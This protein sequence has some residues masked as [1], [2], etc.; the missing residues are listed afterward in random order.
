MLIVYVILNNI[1]NSTQ[2]DIYF[3]FT[4]SDKTRR[5]SKLRLRVPPPD[6][7]GEAASLASRAE[8]GGASRASRRGG[9]GGAARGAREA[10]GGAA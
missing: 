8:G 5:R 1:I 10:A 2:F 4:R 9:G 7:A 6:G 3:I